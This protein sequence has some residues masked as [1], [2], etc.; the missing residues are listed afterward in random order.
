MPSPLLLC[1]HVSGKKT[2]LGN[3]E[4]EPDPQT[5]NP[6][7]D[8][9]VHG[10]RKIHAGI[11]ENFQNLKS[12]IQR[13]E[14]KF[15]L[16]RTRKFACPETSRQAFDEQTFLRNVGGKSQMFSVRGPVASA[17]PCGSGPPYLPSGDDVL[18]GTPGLR[19]F[20][21]LS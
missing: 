14:I 9:A 3:W 16:Q 11:K 17:R 12:E 6:H 1:V 15:S 10:S 5:H 7:V 13:F 20:Q 2:Y 4:P 19:S 8:S 18:E 21:Y